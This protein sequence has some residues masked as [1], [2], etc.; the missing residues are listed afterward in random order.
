MN[1]L[2]VPGCRRAG[3]DEEGREAA[4]AACGCSLEEGVGFT[5]GA[6]GE[7]RQYCHGGIRKKMR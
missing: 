3:Q 4:M 5:A 6:A 7:S 1:G 2:I